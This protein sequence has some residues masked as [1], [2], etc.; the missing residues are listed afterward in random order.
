MV[1]LQREEHD[2]TNPE[3]NAKYNAMYAQLVAWQE[4]DE[5]ICMKWMAEFGAVAD[6]DYEQNRA[7][8]A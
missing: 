5:S 2:M 4:A 6:A 7:L 3:L 8:Y 1:F